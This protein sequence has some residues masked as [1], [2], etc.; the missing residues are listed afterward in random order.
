[1]GELQGKRFSSTGAGFDS[2]LESGGAFAARTVAWWNQSIV[3][4]TASLAPRS[5]PYH[6]LVTTHGGFIGTLVKTLIRSGK[7]KCDK[8]VVIWKCLNSSITVIEIESNG[9]GVVVKY[10]D[11]AHLVEKKV[12]ETNADEVKINLNV[13]DI[14]IR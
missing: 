8:G 6:V 7:A 3:Q 4:P 9:K 14:A 10:G 13:H 5:I 2:N 11:I 1:M 12:V